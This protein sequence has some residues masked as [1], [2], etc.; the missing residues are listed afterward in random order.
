[1]SGE[2]VAEWISSEGPNPADGASP[3]ALAVAFGI[4]VFLV[5]TFRA[6]LNPDE[7]TTA[8]LNDKRIIATLIGAGIYWL[9][10][11]SISRRLDQPIG[12]ILRASLRIVVLGSLVLLSVR[13]AIDVIYAI[14]LQQSIARNVR[15]LL[16]W[17]GYFAT[18][19]AGFVAHA[20][21]LRLRVVEAPNAR[22]E[23][24]P[25]R[26]LALDS[27]AAVVLL[28]S[29]VNRLGDNSPVEKHAIAAQLMDR[30]GY[31]CADPL[32]TGNDEARATI[33]R[34]IAFQLTRDTQ[35]A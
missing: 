25:V 17:L 6:A 28:E 13:A 11:R 33:L 7:A 16:L 2:A 32:S 5:F 10:L 29:I 26:G 30:A 20:Y 19:V 15:W 9:T 3:T 1:M 8:L 24:L 34:E 12:N 4:F 35:S 23:R 18:W 14:D 21:Y 22:T 31:E 27:E